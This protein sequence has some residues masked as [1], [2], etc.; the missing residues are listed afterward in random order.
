[1]AGPAANRDL[2]ADEE[3]PCVLGDYATPACMAQADGC[4]AFNFRIPDRTAEYMFVYC[5]C[6]VPCKAAVI[7]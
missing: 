4:D 5:R 2:S 1:M 3:R 7:E 6:H